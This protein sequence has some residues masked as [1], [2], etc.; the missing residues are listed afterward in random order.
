M[1]IKWL[2]MN[3]QSLNNGELIKMLQETLNSE[4]AF[5]VEL[6][7]KQLE[8]GQKSDGTFLKEYSQRTIK[9]RAMEG[10]PVKGDLIALYD[11]GDFWKGFWAMAYGGKLEIWSSDPKANQ[12]VADYGEKIF[13]LTKDN[14]EEL[15]KVIVPKLRRRIIKFLR[16]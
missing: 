13:G 12:L 2:E 4:K 16:K 8:K 3:L 15:E 11:S 10:N 14:F 5:I 6:N 9:I 1:G 7:K